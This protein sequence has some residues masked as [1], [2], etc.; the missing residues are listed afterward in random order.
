MA[1]IGSVVKL[2]LFAQVDGSTVQNE[3]GTVEVDVKLRPIDRAVDTEAA[4]EATMVASLDLPTALR[5]MA[6]RLEVP[7]NS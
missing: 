5:A 6:D 3:I 4:A 1:T 2:R 7:L